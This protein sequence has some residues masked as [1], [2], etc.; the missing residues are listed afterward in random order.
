MFLAIEIFVATHTSDCI[1]NVGGTV[2]NTFLTAAPERHSCRIPRTI[3]F[4]KSAGMLVRTIS[5]REHIHKIQSRTK[6]QQM[7]ISHFCAATILI[8][9][10]NSYKIF[11]VDSE[12]NLT[13]R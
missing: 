9:C 4:S 13:N 10:E 3:L 6:T 2:K 1:C 11:I 8:L 7:N 5:A 12:A